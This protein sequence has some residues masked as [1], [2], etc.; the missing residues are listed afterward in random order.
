MDFEKLEVPLYILYGFSDSRSVFPEHFV[1][2][3]EHQVIKFLN[4]LNA[5]TLLK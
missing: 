3:T 4:V 2:I 1:V 5:K